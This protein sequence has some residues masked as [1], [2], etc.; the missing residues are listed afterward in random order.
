MP[1]QARTLTTLRRILVPLD[2]KVAAKSSIELA[3]LVAQSMAAHV[4]VLLIGEDPTRDEDKYPPNIED[5]PPPT[6]TSRIRGHQKIVES[7]SEEI[8]KVLDDLCAQHGVKIVKNKV[9]LKKVSARWSVDLGEPGK[10]VARHGR[11]SDLIVLAKPTSISKIRSKIHVV[12]ALFETGRPVLVAPTSTPHSIGRKIAV[13]WNDSAGASRAV[14]AA[15]RFLNRADE[16]VIVTAESK[17][18]P[19]RVAEEL[20]EYFTLHGITAECDVFT[21]MGDKP[22]GGKALLE[23]CRRVGADM[24]VMGAYQTQSIRGA[25]M[26]TATE[27]VLESTTIPVLMAR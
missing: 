23:E 7:R 27:Q 5:L 3:F 20:A 24:L 16:V 15:M 2:S 22:L 14:A 19:A 10:V 1:K 25:I 17:R 9:P 21:Q 13:S 11:R 26:G 6:G 18:T 12:T 8:R 4:D